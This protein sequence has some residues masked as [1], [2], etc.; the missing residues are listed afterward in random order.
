MRAHIH[1]VVILIN[2]RRVVGMILPVVK[3]VASQ[4]EELVSSQSK[5]PLEKRLL[6]SSSLFLTQSVRKYY[7]QPYATSS[8]IAQRTRDA[9]HSS[10]LAR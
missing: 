9:A 6:F 4:L 7:T 10:A 1:T 3:W 5:N 8:S 2:Q